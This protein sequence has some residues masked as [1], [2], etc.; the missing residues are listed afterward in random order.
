MDIR[1]AVVQKFTEKHLK[2]IAQAPN[3]QV[4]ADSIG[5]AT[6]KGVEDVL[7]ERI[8]KITKHWNGTID[9]VKLNASVITEIDNRVKQVASTLIDEAVITT[10]KTLS[11]GLAARIAGAVKHRLDYEIGQEV[12]KQV[13]EAFRRALEG[14]TK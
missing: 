8:G 13:G 1:N 6:K 11:E 7:L 3:I 10:T 2:A 9:N 14:G 4:I 5:A 12:K